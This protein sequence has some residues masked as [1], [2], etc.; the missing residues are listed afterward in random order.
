VTIEG[1]TDVRGD[2]AYNQALSERRAAAVRAWLVGHGVD[3]AR[4]SATG[5]GESRPV[6]TGT[7]EADH[8]ANR[9]VEIRIQG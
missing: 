3:A 6:R 2:A 1:H 7:T 8:R 9:R 4:I 5:A